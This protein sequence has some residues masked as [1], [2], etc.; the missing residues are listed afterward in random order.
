MSKHMV[1]AG[2][3]GQLGKALRELF[4][5]ATA[6]GRQEPDIADWQQVQVLNG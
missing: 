2:Y 3:N 4:P 5:E 1:I 6:Q